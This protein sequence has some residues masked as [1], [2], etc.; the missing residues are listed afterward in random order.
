[1]RSVTKSFAVVAIV[2][3]LA[4]P[5]LQAASSRQRPSHPRTFIQIVKHWVVT[6]LGDE[7]SV[8]HP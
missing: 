1:M 6:M 8:P 4:A 2:L 3:S 7:M 5:S